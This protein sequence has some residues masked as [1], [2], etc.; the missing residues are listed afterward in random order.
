MKKEKKHGERKMFVTPFVVCFLL[1]GFVFG[2]ER[3][4]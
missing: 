1:S 4:F 3:E 2:R